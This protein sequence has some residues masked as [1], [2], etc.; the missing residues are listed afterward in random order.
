MPSAGPDAR[1]RGPSTSPAAIASRSATSVKLY[2]PTSRVVVT[3]DSSVRRAL[4]AP[5][6]A[7]RGTESP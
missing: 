4:A 5:I 6:S 3:P 1:T 7:R 2:E